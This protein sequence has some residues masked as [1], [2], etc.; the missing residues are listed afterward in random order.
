MVSVCTRL[1]KSKKAV[2]MCAYTSDI[3]QKG[4]F[5]GYML[6][7]KDKEMGQKKVMVTTTMMLTESKVH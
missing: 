4:K 7:D 6:I 5:T 1:A 2:C 3:L